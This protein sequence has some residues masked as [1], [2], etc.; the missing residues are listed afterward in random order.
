MGEWSAPIPYDQSPCVNT[1]NP[2]NG[3]R[4]EHA[5]GRAFGFAEGHK[6]TTKLLNPSKSRANRNN[7]RVASQSNGIRFEAC[8]SSYS[9]QALGAEPRA[10][11][12][13][14]WWLTCQPSWPWLEEVCVCKP[15]GSLSQRPSLCGLPSQTAHP[16]SC[17]C[18]CRSLFCR[19]ALQACEASEPAGGLC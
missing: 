5:L 2:S 18:V 14:S 11:A 17:V 9:P 8:G 19:W 7:K 12:K 13:P 6:V 16:C 15:S 4:P 3:R 10:T 1:C